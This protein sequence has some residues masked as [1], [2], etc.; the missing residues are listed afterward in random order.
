MKTVTVADLRINF[1]ALAPARRLKKLPPL[2][3]LARL[4]KQFPQGPAAGD[5]RTLVDYDRGD[6]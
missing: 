6:R 3:R 4:R 2:D 1:A 5:S